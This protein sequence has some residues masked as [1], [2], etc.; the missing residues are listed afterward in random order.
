MEDGDWKVFI[1]FS[2]MKVTG[3]LTQT[4]FGVVLGAEA[5]FD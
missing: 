1:W 3:D 4:Y 2:V 5:R